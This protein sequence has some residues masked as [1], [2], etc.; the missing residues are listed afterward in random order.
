[1]TTTSTEPGRARHT[2][3]PPRHAR[4]TVLA[5]AALTIMAPAV[6]APALPGMATDFGPGS[7]EMVRLV[8]TVT[9]LA[10]AVGAPVA[11]ALVD[12]VGPRPVLITGLVLYA[13]A[14]TTGLH[15]QSLLPLL[16]ARVVLGLAVGGITTAVT[17]QVTQ[18]FTG[19]R[20]AGYLGLQQATA[21]LGGIVFLPL[22]GLLADVDWRA[23]FWLYTAAVPLAV[24][25]IAAWRSVATPGGHAEGSG[26]PGTTPGRRT[27]AARIAGTYLLAVVA[28]AVFY[29][30]PTQLPF[31]LDGRGATPP[32]VGVAV[33]ASTLASLI[34]ALALA[35]VRGRW[36]SGTVT[37]VA[38]TLLGIGWGVTGL[39]GTIAGIVAGLLVG[40]LGAG[41][42][43]PNLNHVL[44]D[45]APARHT[46]RV[47]AGLVSAIFLGQFVSPILLDPLVTA[48][49]IAGAFALAGALT[50]G[51]ALIGVVVHAIASRASLAPSSDAPDPSGNH[52]RTS[53]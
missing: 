5:A 22:A 49:G 41:L 39:S 24:A 3:H 44:A 17:A 12:R 35:R 40:G 42:A 47:L 33:A 53:P 51:G 30:A 25:L 10:I 4:V 6:I 7:D 21:S 37:V 20:R 36:N 46:G 28:T 14:G 9:S 32:A 48:V 11:G 1:M 26:T 50:V 2:A 23:P 18:W 34:G 45:L 52:G 16:A 43:V 15:V 27:A 31:L 19:R 29:M 38:I 13:A 8:L